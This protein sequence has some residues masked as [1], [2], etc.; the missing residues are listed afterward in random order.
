L[1]TNQ[2]PPLV[3]TLS[4]GLILRTARDE[5]DIE[6]LAQFNGLIHS[7]DLIPTVRGLATHYPGMDYADWA[8]VEDE[9]TGEVI[10]SLCLIPWM[11]R[12]GRVDLR[13][14]E[15]GLVG[16]LEAYRRR[17]LVR[18]QIDYFKQRLAERG[19]HL[20]LIQGI[21][22]YYRQFGYEYALPLEGGLRLTGRELPN[23]AIPDFSFRRATVD[24]LTILQRLYNE[25]AADVA[26]SV[27]RDEIGWR[28]Q[29]QHP[30]ATERIPEFWLVLDAQG[31]I[32][33]YFMLPEHHFGEELTIGEVSR[34]S[35]GATL[36]VL[37]RCRE[38]AAERNLPGIRLNLPANSAISQLA[39]AVGA[40]DMGTYSWQIHVVDFADLLRAIAPVLEDRLAASPFAGMTRDVQIAFFRDSVILR[41]VDGKITEVAAGGP[42]EGAI[43][44]PP[45]TII[46]LIFG[47]RT[48]AD[49]RAA[50]P[51][52]NAG[53][54][55]RLLMETLF[56]QTPA[57][58][59]SGY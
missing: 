33:G 21:P 24:D 2:K 9:K 12:Y 28:Y 38:I 17:G 6:R 1:T 26:I 10:S 3:Q 43:N 22:Y 44:F 11:L 15:M 16:T 46:P 18:I 54:I 45:L 53:G 48:I 4:D 5:A 31:E 40:Y 35:F 30:Q 57:F 19:C 32:A 25:A 14:G 37:R 8:F 27:V 47:Q 50:Y 58:L 49:L 56:P 55:W 23:L 59:Y 42:A 39:R 52:V 34:L 29:L 51:D 36:A 13:V 41:F 7:P 20:S